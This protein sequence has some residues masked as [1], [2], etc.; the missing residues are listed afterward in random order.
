MVTD[1]HKISEQT[2]KI[3]HL[4]RDKDDYVKRI[5]TLEGELKVKASECEFAHSAAQFNLKEKERE[6]GQMRTEI[7]AA[8]G[9]LYEVAK[10]GTETN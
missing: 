5:E 10:N 9:L 6:V 8:I 1:H 7:H 3:S 2:E 4:W